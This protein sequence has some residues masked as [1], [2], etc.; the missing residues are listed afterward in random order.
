M[1]RWNELKAAATR[2][3][4]V[5]KEGKDE[6]SMV[7]YQDLVSCLRAVADSSVVLDISHDTLLA[8]EI[9][10]PVSVEKFAES[11]EDIIVNS[12]ELAQWCQKVEKEQ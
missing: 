9:F 8:L 5:L 2:A 11:L 6:R 4:G 3:A 10:S 1:N 12:D 7:V